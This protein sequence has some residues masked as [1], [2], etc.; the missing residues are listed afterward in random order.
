M[1]PIAQDFQFGV[2]MNEL[3]TPQKLCFIFSVVSKL[4]P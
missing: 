4:G 3:R 1:F 2:D